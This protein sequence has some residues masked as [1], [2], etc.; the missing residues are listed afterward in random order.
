MFLP[1]FG[2]RPARPVPWL[3]FL[4]AVVVLVASF[5]AYVCHDPIWAVIA[6]VAL[7]VTY[8]V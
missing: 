7:V 3:R 5:T 2:G 4:A 8:V 6:C 1:D